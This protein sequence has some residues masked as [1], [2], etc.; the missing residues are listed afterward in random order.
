MGDLHPVDILIYIVNF[1]VTFLLL[2][3]LLYKPVSVF[4]NNRRKR[5]EESIAEAETKC[6]EAEALHKEAKASLEN[7]A[8][9]ARK[10]TH[11]MIENAAL[12]AERVR[13]NAEDE[14]SALIA[15]AKEQI[16]IARQ[17]ALESAYVEYISLA[18]DM[19][20]RIL[21]REVSIAD[22]RKI[23]DIFFEEDKARR[24]A[25]PET[26]PSQGMGEDS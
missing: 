6:I 26:G 22:N 3:L 12:D 8:D 5:V 16:N 1:F 9:E 23:A 4:M 15:H 11:E 24:D 7:A 18:G 20:S 25:V 13:D 2:Y 14:A 10:R 19:V 17:S 21:T